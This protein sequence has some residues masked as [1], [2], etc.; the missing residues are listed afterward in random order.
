GE[1]G[2][3]LF[4]GADTGREVGAAHASAGSARDRAESRDDGEVPRT[5]EEVLLRPGEVQDV[6]RAA[7]DS[8]PHR[9][10]VRFSAPL[11]VRRG[12]L[13][14]PYV[15]GDHRIEADEAAVFHFFLDVEDT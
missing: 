1:D 6:P 7:R 4:R 14:L 13:I 2:E 10:E 15:I 9:E 3:G 8:V 12:Q 11:P 5:D